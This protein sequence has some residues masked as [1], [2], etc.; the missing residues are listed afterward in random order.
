METTEEPEHSPSG[1]TVIR[2]QVPSRIDTSDPDWKYI[3][4]QRLLIYLEHSLDQGLQWTV[5]EP[6][7]EPLWASVQRTISDFLTAEWRSGALKGAS[8]EEAF[9]VRCDRTTMTQQD[10]D[11]GRLVAV[12]GVAPLRPAEFVVF[13][14]GQWT[15][16]ASTPSTPPHCGQ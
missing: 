10:I 15:S 7:D 11:N 3:D 1:P 4:V 14:I 9:F 13:Q 5:F 6:N 2:G 12:V 16:P 8:A